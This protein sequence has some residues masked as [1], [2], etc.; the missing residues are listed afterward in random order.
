MGLTFPPPRGLP[1]I[2]ITGRGGYRGG[3]YVARRSWGGRDMGII[4]GDGAGGREG[5][6]GG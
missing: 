4:D 3:L 1:K 5:E 2:E 6:F